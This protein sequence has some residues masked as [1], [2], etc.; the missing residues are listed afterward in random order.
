[1]ESP[2]GPIT[3]YSNG[4]S[5]TGL[6]IGTTPEVSDPDAITATAVQ[7]LSEYFAG[8]R[9]SFDLPVET[10]G[11][12]FQESIWGALQNIPYGSSQSY[13]ELGERAGKPGAARAVG[14]AVGA[15]PLPIVIPCHRVLASDLKITGYSGGDGIAT[16]QKLLAL[17]GITYR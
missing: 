3:L 2:V 13:G 12:P 5:L 1:M 7:Q 10:R 15:N 6:E 9:T 14:S 4:T 8:T 16:K 17:E 11:T